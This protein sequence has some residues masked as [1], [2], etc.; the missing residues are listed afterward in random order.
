MDDPDRDS[1]A[2]ALR[3]VAQQRGAV[4]GRW[5]AP[6][7]RLVLVAVAMGAAV[8]SLTIDTVAVVGVA[9]LVFLVGLVLLF[10]VPAN[11]GVV[12]RGGVGA[13]GQVFAGG[14]VLLAVFTGAL[15]G[16]QQGVD[17][18]TGV[19]GVVAAVAAVVV[20]WWHFVQVRR[21]A[22]GRPEL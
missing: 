7:R 13:F 15:V 20:G 1:A 19:A 5:G 17:W 9:A 10:G 21:T 12:P 16:Q 6:W 18:V 3:D 4:A 2:A 11:S 14:S 8:A 22:R